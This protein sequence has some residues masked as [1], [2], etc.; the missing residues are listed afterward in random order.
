MQF[1]PPVHTANPPLHTAK[2]RARL[3]RLLRPTWR[4]LREGAA[5]RGAHT[6]NNGFGCLQDS[7]RRRNLPAQLSHL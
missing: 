6:A 1:G 5:F 4:E 2:A 7:K 3:V